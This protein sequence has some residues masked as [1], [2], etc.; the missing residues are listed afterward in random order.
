MTVFVCLISRT[1][2]FPLLEFIFRN[3]YPLM[4]PFFKHNQK[5]S[6]WFSRCLMSTL[7]LCWEINNKVI[8]GVFIQKFGLVTIFMCQGVELNNL[9]MEMNN[10]WMLV[11]HVWCIITPLWPPPQQTTILWRNKESVLSN[12]IIIQEVM[13]FISS[14]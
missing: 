2:V 14:S 12:F 3:V 9:K 6:C 5:N 7:Y 4:K 1:V 10:T 13:N 8:F 11:A